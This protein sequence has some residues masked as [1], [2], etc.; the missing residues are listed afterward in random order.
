M[1]P[2]GEAGI[3]S[4][5]GL[6]AE[7]EVEIGASIWAGAWVVAKA[8]DA[9][10]DRARARITC[11]TEVVARQLPPSAAERLIPSVH[12]LAASFPDQQ[13]QSKWG[14]QSGRSTCAGIYLACSVVAAWSVLC[15]WD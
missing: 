1:G 13:Q 12:A 11:S 4:R 8:R 7:A 10:A 2:G 5:L 14:D 6:G 9:D 3:G 15:A